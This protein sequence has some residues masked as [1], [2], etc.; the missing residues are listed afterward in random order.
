MQGIGEAIATDAESFR[1]GIF[2]ADFQL[3]KI[4]IVAKS[5]T[6]AQH[7][8]RSFATGRPADKLTL[9][10]NDARTWLAD[11]HQGL[12]QGSLIAA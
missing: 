10:L 1:P 4:L 7:I 12:D 8:A 2:Q 11:I 9:K 6:F 3:E 5:K